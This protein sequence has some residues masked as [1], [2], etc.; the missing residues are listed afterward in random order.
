MLLLPVNLLLS[1]IEY[2]AP[3]IKEVVKGTFSIFGDFFVWK[4]HNRIINYLD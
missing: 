4:K 2:S 3:E 1:S